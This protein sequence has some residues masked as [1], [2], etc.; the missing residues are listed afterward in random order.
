MEADR[1]SDYLRARRAYEFGRLETSARRA[2]VVVA[3][4]AATTW[5]LAGAHALVWIPLSLAAWVVAYWRGEA[6]LR[7]AW[8]GLLGGGATF[9]LPMSMLRPC[10]VGRVV[11]A[12]AS[13]CTMPG[14]CVGAG[15]VVGLLLA[16]IVPVTRESWSKVAGG[17]ALGAASV[18][19]L[20]CASLFAGE[21]LGLV[22]GLLVGLAAA[23]AARAFLRRSP[24]AS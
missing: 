2:A 17:M 19:V 5:F 10:C 6:V 18:A 16:T 23:S 20:R 15:A 21:A 4:I 13:C 7:G 9:L 14:A 8:L 1:S 11:E 3:P 12:G 22:G 24:Q